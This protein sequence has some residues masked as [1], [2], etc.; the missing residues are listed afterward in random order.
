MALHAPEQQCLSHWVLLPS[1]G[2]H[3]QPQ[4]ATGS[5]VAC[6]VIWDG[7][8]LTLVFNLG[9]VALL[10]LLLN[11]N[12]VNGFPSGYIYPLSIGRALAVVIAGGTEFAVAS[13]A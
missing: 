10:A 5:L 2:V 9:L 13:T 6:W 12:Q 11:L 4:A 1:G 3:A 8:C 7:A